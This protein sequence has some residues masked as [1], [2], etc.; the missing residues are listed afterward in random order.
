MAKVL[1]TLTQKSA[2]FSSNYFKLEQ[3]FEENHFNL[4][5][6]R[7]FIFVIRRHRIS[8]NQD[9]FFLVK[10]ITKGGFLELNFQ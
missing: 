6:I 9:F 7:Y 2:M 8:I 3:Y 5:H 1:R 10:I 4:L